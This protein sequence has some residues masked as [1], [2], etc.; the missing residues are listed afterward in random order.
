M[1]LLIKTYVVYEKIPNE[2]KYRKIK[3]H[4][5]NKQIYNYNIFRNIYKS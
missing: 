2:R 4:I 1:Y 5:F 3:L